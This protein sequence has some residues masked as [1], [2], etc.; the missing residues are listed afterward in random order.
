[1]IGRAEG[2][3]ARAVL[4]TVPPINP[5]P[6]FTRHAREPFAAAGGLAQVLA[7][8]RAAVLRLGVELGLP[9]VDLAQDLTASP[10]WLSADGVHPSPAGNTI[11]ARLVAEKVAPLLARRTSAAGSVQGTGPRGSP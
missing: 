7:N 1:M 4:C 3:S 5:E 9:V 11:I 6:Y 10:E 2:I 8:Y